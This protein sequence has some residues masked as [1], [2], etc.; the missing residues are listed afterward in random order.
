MGGGGSQSKPAP[1]NRYATGAA[2]GYVLGPQDL[3]DSK[4]TEGAALFGGPG[5]GVGIL[6]DWGEVVDISQG[7]FFGDLNSPNANPI[8][9]KALEGAFSTPEI[10]INMPSMGGF[11]GG[12]GGGFGAKLIPGSSVANALDYLENTPSVF[13]QMS[14]GPIVD[15]IN[16]RVNAEDAAYTQRAMAD[17][18]EATEIAF[19]N[20]MAQGLLS[21]S[22]IMLNRE[23]LAE[24]VLN[25]LNVFRATRSLEQTK[26]LGDLAMQ[27]IINQSNNMQSIIQ[28]ALEE[29]G[30]DANYAAQMAAIASEQA[31]AIAVAQLNSQ[32][33]L[34]MNS[35]DNSLAL[36]GMGMQDYQAGIDR[37]LGVLTKPLD[38][39]AGIGTS[40]GGS[41]ANTPK[42]P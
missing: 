39:V 33:Q 12:G 25:D 27:D 26:Y 17:L 30:I 24:N 36:L 9:T 15:E 22:T 11:G 2:L 4:A 13:D 31:T 34:A 28:A 38:L 5:Q 23:R 10:K 41:I 35:Q 40:G 3:G 16:Q 6:P 18:E 32:T 42:S 29:K 1:E 20:D 21:G 7:S 19:A 37:Q 14:G 8:F